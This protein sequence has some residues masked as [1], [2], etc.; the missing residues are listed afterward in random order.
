MTS[1]QEILEAIKSLTRIQIS[2]NRDAS[3]NA[4]ETALLKLDFSKNLT[5]EKID[6]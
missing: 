2:V 6:Y 3:I 1:H 5:G 4:L